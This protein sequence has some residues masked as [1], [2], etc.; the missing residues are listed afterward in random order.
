[1]L[2]PQHGCGLDP[3]A[4]KH[5]GSGTRRSVVDDDGHV[6][7]PDRLQA[8]RHTGSAESARRRDAHGAT[9]DT[10]SPTVSSRPRAR[11]A[12]CTACP[13][14]PLTRLSSALTTTARPLCASAATCRWTL[15]LPA[16]AAVVGQAPSGSRCT[17][18]SDSYAVANAS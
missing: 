15:L 10:G 1:L 14:A 2:R 18:G 7:Q 8:G 6:E 5:A 17:N 13:A 4:R 16:V 3:V 9:P 12:F 11:L